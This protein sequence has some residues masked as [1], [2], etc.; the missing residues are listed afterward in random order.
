M[1][2]VIYK[3]QAPDGSILKISGP[4]DASNEEIEAFAAKQFGQSNVNPKTADRIAILQKEYLD[5]N[6]RML[7][8]EDKAMNSPSEENKKAYDRL[9]RDVDAVRR[10]LAKIGPEHVPSGSLTSDQED[11]IP[12]SVTTTTEDLQKK[13]DAEAEMA[14][15]RRVM[16]DIGG[17]GAGAVLGKGMEMGRHGV[18]TLEAI[19]NMP[20]ALRSVS[21]APSGASSGA[22]WLKNW[23]GIDKPGFSGGVPEA[24]G[25]YNRMKPQGDIM[26]AL[27]K[28]GLITPQ[29]VQ[30]GVFT[31]GQLSIKG[32]PPAAPVPAAPGALK[33][34]LGALARSPILSGALGGLSATEQGQEFYKRY[35]ENDIPGM[36]ISGTGA[37][38]GGMQ[39]IPHPA[40]RTIG[41]GLSAASPLTM[42]L[43]DKLRSNRQSTPDQRPTVGIM[44]EPIQ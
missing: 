35:K 23:G 28:K 43:Y 6:K 24:A 32:Q 30:P 8:A 21:A 16:A 42:Y 44:G 3:V 40:T 17:A 4:E 41:A 26:G 34:G 39:L 10:E 18:Q 27:A 9:V 31:G 38:G 13:A 36:M 33:T 14:L 5:A 7:A 1:A 2:D 25:Q 11:A 22:N 37:L 19:R 12:A 20:D 29:P 15:K